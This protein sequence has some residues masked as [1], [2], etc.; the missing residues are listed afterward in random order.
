[1]HPT[2]VVPVLVAFGNG[3]PLACNAALRVWL[4]KSNPGMLTRWKELVSSYLIEFREIGDEKDYGKCQNQVEFVVEMAL[5]FVDE[6][7]CS[8][9]RAGAFRVEQT[10]RESFHHT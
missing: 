7:R 1:M 5:W 4:E 8:L 10:R 6:V 3:T 2:I 9:R